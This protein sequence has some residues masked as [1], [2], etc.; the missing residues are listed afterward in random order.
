MKKFNINDH[1]KVKL[2]DFGKDVFYH[3]YDEFNKRF[4]KEIITPEYPKVDADGFTEIQFWHLMNI[5]GPCVYNGMREVPF[6]G[7]VIYIRDDDLE[8]L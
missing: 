6:E 4:G 3:Q 2:T 8:G 5:F 1:V 7:C